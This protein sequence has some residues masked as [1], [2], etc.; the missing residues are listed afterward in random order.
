VTELLN[1]WSGLEGGNA[2]ECPSGTGALEIFGYTGSQSHDYDDVVELFVHTTAP[3]FTIEIVNETG[4]LRTVAVMDDLPGRE[5]VT[6]EDPTVNG[7]GWT[8]PVLLR[9]TDEW[10]TGAFV[11]LL[12]A[13]RDGETIT[14]EAFFVRRPRAG[15][16]KRLVMILTTGTW[17][18]Y[19]DWGRGNHYRSV[20]DG[21]STDNPI[22]EV[23][24]MRPW[25]RGFIR[26]PAE[27]PRHSD[28]PDLPIGAHP[29]YGWLRWAI[30][31]GYSRHY[32]DAGWAHYE[33]PFAKWLYENG[34][35]FDI[36]TQDDLHFRSDSLDAY[37][38]ALLVGHDEYWSWEMRDT[39]DAFQD[40]GG[41]LA[42][43]GGNMIWQIR[44]E[45]NGTR[46]ICY[47]ISEID[48]AAA[49]NP[50]RASTHWDS[51]HI[52][53]PAAN[54]FGLS[55]LWGCYHRFGLCSPRSP[56]G[57]TI[58]RPD[59]WCLEGTDLRYGDVFGAGESRILSFEVDGLDYTF[60][61]GLPYAVGTEGSPQSLQIV[62]LAP[63]ASGEPVDTGKM[64]NAPIAEV[65]AVLE[66]EPSIYPRPPESRAY[67]SAVMASYSRGLGEGFNSGC[68][69]WVS[70]L[71]RH[72]QSVC[73]IT[74]NVLDRFLNK[75]N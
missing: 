75:G 49:T 12:H 47:R 65:M 5:Q 73:R 45:D 24:R 58:Y 32:S 62:A 55:G 71:I 36:L 6:N 16:E 17:Q 56:A 15:E 61:Y 22:P 2:T 54:T 14:R 39:I 67:G 21:I 27:A 29:P 59:H 46:Q 33:R 34:Y 4:A 44:I 53:R 64:V 72:D 66:A 20:E 35:E 28:V 60:R 8:D 52:D 13:E 43:F 1:I 7:C 11:V 41:R 42:R 31:N 9:P 51:L 19:N 57:Y 68:C 10:G 23:S 26:H 74:R 37:G 63:A 48:P 40:R 38:V 3:R 18:A 30:D 69:E 50:R 25:A 70:G